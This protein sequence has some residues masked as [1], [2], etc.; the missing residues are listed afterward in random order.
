MQSHG[1]CATCQ[2]SHRVS[3][4][5]HSSARHQ[6][7]PAGQAYPF[8]VPVGPPADRFVQTIRTAAPEL[9]PCPVPVH[10]AALSAVLRRPRRSTTTQPPATAVQSFSFNRKPPPARSTAPLIVAVLVRTCR[11]RVSLQGG[12]HACSVH[13]WRCVALRGVAC[14]H[15]VCL[16]GRILCPEVDAP[17]S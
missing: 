11:V 8:P 2:P 14:T 17:W 12:S 9:T 10:A 16:T 7:A 15:W 6:R 3:R 5:V 1:V 4:L 13:A